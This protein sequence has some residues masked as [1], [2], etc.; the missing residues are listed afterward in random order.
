MGFEEN[1]GIYFN[2]LD[3]KHK[4]PKRAREKNQCIRGLGSSSG[5]LAPRHSLLP[6]YVHPLF[7]FVWQCT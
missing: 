2:W 7:C 4:V 3:S 5:G 1:G 6:I